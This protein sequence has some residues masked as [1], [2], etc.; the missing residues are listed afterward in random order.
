MSA[1]FRIFLSSPSDVLEE[2]LRAHLVVQKLAR[3]Y[4]RFF[5]I[6]P[7]L[8]EHEPMLASGHFQDAIEPPS[9]ADIVVLILWSRL[10]MPLPER[11][12]VREYHGIDGRVPVTGTEW[13]FED[14]LAASRAKGTPDILAYRRL[15]DPGAS[16]TDAAL[17][18]EQQRQW[19]ALEAFWHRYFESHGNSLA[20]SAR[21]ETLEEFDHKLEA[22]LSHLLERR[23]KNELGKGLEKE[24]SPIWLK[25]SPFRGLSAYDFT[26]API[27]FGRDGAIR[28][29]LIR[30]AEAASRKTAFLLILGASG[31]GK[32]S[33]AKAG[34]LPS[35]VSAKAVPSVGL[36]RRVVMR[37]G[38][39]H[40]DPILA[41]AQALLT[42]D[43][44]RGEGLPELMGSSM[45]VSDLVQHLRAAAEG[46]SLPF[47]TTLHELATRERRTRAMLPHEDARLVLLVD[48][49]EEL[50]TRSNVSAPD[51]RLFVRILS[52]LCKSGVVWVIATMRS[53]LWHRAATYPEVLSLVEAGSRL[54]LL[55]PDSAELLEMIRQPASAA[56][57]SFEFD[58]ESGIGLDAVIARAAN[59]EPGAL[60]LLSVMLETLYKR[61]IS[62]GE[63]REGSPPHTLTFAVY[64][65]LGELKG[66][67]GQRAEET[68]TALEQS[69][70]AA[71]SALPQVLRA[72]LTTAAG[73]VVTAR[74]APL[75]QFGNGSPEQRLIEAFLSPKSRL[76]TAED[77]G[78]GPEVRLAHEALIEHWPR[79]KQ[80]VAADRHDIETRARLE[81]LL[82]RYEEAPQK[83][84]K[85]ALLGG[86]PLEEGRDLVQRWT[87]PATTPLGV[88]IAVSNAAA[89]R[90]RYGFIATAAALIL[91]FASIAIVAV[92]N[93]RKAELSAA[94]AL[95]G[96]TVQSN[97]D[98]SHS[99][100]F[101]NS[102]KDGAWGRLIPQ[103]SRLSPIN[104]L[105]L[106]ADD[107]LRSLVLPQQ[108]NKLQS[109][110]VTDNTNLKHVNL[111]REL[112]TLVE[113]KFSDNPALSTII[114]PNKLSGLSALIV[115]RNPALSVL[116][117]P[118]SLPLLKSLQVQN[119]EVLTTIRIPQSLP[120]LEALYIRNNPKLEAL[121]LP[122]K[123]NTLNNLQVL[124]NSSLTA[125]GLSQ[126][127]LKL[128]QLY[129]RNNSKLPLLELPNGL[130]ELRELDIS[131]NEVLSALNL[132]DTMEKLRSLVINE[133]GR[134][135]SFTE[136]RKVPN[137]EVVALS[138]SLLVNLGT[139]ELARLP[140]LRA[141]LL[142]ADN[143]IALELKEKLTEIR[144]AS[145]LSPVE[146]YYAYP[147]TTSWETKWRELSSLIVP[148]KD[149]ME[150]CRGIDTKIK[151]LD[152]Q[153]NHIQV[154][155]N[156]LAKVTVEYAV[157]V[158]FKP[159]E[160]GGVHPIDDRTCTYYPAGMRLIRATTV[161]ITS[162]TYNL[163][164][165]IMDLPY[166]KPIY[167]K[168]DCNEALETLLFINAHDNASGSRD[169]WREYINRDQ[170]DLL[171]E[172]SVEG[173]K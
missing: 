137:L 77:Q 105:V 26:D 61:D 166:P 108:L 159:C 63:A 119:N 45:T 90:K 22:D 112:E 89:R 30:L 169:S 147:S 128:S 83:D 42:G 25:G 152:T 99:L 141:L 132:Y 44:A 167:Y 80:Q 116:D 20:G 8:W 71:A 85:R 93:Q 56:G 29:A 10:G 28:T 67:I 35:L 86:L 54:E 114:L 43:P 27:F 64:R 66:A 164:K 5:S 172:L 62:E 173:F 51:R 117:L 50:F 16:L 19:S 69:D 92:Q 53:D 15:G 121:Q 153:H 106:A 140:N 122:S 17:R 41:L 81:S 40:A 133:N 87:I 161:E 59:E 104:S 75:S 123:L 157:E 24:R 11:T 49:L 131:N 143:K 168:G 6:E 55:P 7:Y 155:S 33:L 72:L 146:I 139:A 13:E 39:A 52:G 46:A 98:S 91:M 162:Q 32:S 160:S 38:D 115:L 134:L 156:R 94:F 129:V 145:G 130:D 74:A 163:P 125:L 144:K 18:A 148:P 21:Y 4:A 101:S 68:I 73:N 170:P 142:P 1:R 150:K 14:A 60:P 84:K 109:L 154:A 23:I 82:H 9:A 138:G 120:E 103:L 47:K 78:G 12:R 102:A 149:E 95:E 111:S 34:L 158:G 97:T 76:F 151:M 135:M 2:R 107:D 136:W 3:D 165:K 171:K 96:V 70:P 124:D 110:H 57:L 31:S 118:K 48:Q 127:L 37:P 88:F 65:A 113:L 126:S 58:A 100:I 36:W 79:A